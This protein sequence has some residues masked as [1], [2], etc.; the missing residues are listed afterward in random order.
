MGSFSYLCSEC[1]HP[2]RSDCHTGEHCILMV[3]DEGTVLEWMQ[4]QYNGYGK[5]FKLDD[6]V[7]EQGNL[8]DDDSYEWTALSHNQIHSLHFN[9]CSSSGIAAY[10]SGCFDGDMTRVC[11]SEND[12]EQGDL[13]Y[14]RDKRKGKYTFPQRGTHAHGIAIKTQPKWATAEDI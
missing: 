2:I 6:D 8:P 3:V 5:V 13:D 9:G 1:G 4:G 14:D 10:H 11:V 12:P 7:L